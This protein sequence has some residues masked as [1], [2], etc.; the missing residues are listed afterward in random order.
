[1]SK[2]L[3]HTQR[4]IAAAARVAK[5]QGV[6]VRLEKDGSITIIPEIPTDNPLDTPRP[7]GGLSP[8]E[9]WRKERAGKA[10][11]RPHG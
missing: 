4:Q 1:M 11:G 10:R 5:Q 3:A 7:I 6:A 9:A 2:P 8:I